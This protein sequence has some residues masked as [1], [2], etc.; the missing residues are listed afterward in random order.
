MARQNS[1][2]PW[3]SQEILL[4]KHCRRGTF[5]CSETRKYR[6]KIF[7][8]RTSKVKILTRRLIPNGLL[9]KVNENNQTQLSLLENYKWLAEKKFL[10]ANI[11]FGSQLIIIHMCD[12]LFFLP[13]GSNAFGLFLTNLASP[14]TAWLNQ[15]KLG[16]IVAE[17]LWLNYREANKVFCCPC[18]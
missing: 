5:C 15:E 7:A 17:T 3:L 8:S 13:R 14:E 16:N 1:K 6:S 4:R 9:E 10:T 18:V 12:P 11:F 2:G